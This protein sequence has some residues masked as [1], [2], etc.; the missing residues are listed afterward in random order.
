MKSDETMIGLD[1]KLLSGREYV[2]ASRI[3]GPLV[4]MRNTHSVGYGELV[5]CR[6]SQGRRRTGQVLDTSDQTEIGRA[7]CRERV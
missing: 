1:R 7:S 4:Y 2:G 5:E 6:D 3:D